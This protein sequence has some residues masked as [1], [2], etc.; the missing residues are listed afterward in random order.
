MVRKTISTVRHEGPRTALA[1]GVRRGRFVCDV[2]ATTWMLRSEMRRRRSLDES[3]EFAFGFSRGDVTIAP[4]QIPEEIKALLEMLASNPPHT[5]L[6]IGTA[7]GGTLFLLSR[8]A[9]ADAR[10]ASIDLPGGT[11][12]GGYE[13]IWIPLVRS[14]PLRGQRLELI[15]ADSHDPATYA[16]TLEWLAGAPLDFLLIDGDHRF[17]GVR[18]DFLMYGPLVR[19]GGLIAIHDIVPGDEDKVGGVPAF[20]NVVKGIYE[21]RELVHDWEQGGFGLGVVEVPP[22]GIDADDPIL[23]AYG[24]D[25][26]R[27]PASLS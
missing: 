16:Q 14:L 7:R 17:E 12:G 4:A 1:K 25:D 19:P 20:W 23:S 2:A 8:S 10:L 13:R 9:T 21:T 24:P 11:F 26:R 6:E 3:V 15:R 18:R 22:D 5:V 27:E